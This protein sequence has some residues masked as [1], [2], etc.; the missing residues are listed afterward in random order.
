[1]G[2]PSLTFVL[3]PLFWIIFGLSFS[4]IM[5]THLSPFMLSL[6]IISFVGGALNHWMIAQA[7]IR[8][9]GWHSMRLALALYPFY[10]L[11]HSA[12]AAMALYQLIVAPHYWGKTTH[13]VSN[14]FIAD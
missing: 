4:G 10:W 3:A 2:A 12:A 13:G 7:S 1:V 14:V 11:L 8:L 9:E 6:C 5:P